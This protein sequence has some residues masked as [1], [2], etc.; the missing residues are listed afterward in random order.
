MKLKNNFNQRNKMNKNKA[1][2]FYRIM[3]KSLQTGFL[4]H[5]KWL[6]IDKKSLDKWA[7]D[8]NGEFSYINHWVEEFFN[9]PKV[10]LLSE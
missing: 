6:Q 4:S 8:L 10:K 5:G 7:L 3:W 1:P 9:Y 2:Q